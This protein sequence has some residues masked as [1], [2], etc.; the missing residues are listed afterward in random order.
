[1]LRV[2]QYVQP[3]VRNQDGWAHGSHQDAAAPERQNFCG[4]RGRFWCCEW[5]GWYCATV[6]GELAACRR[7]WRSEHPAVRRCVHPA[8]AGVDAQHDRWRSCWRHSSTN[9]LG[10]SGSFDEPGLSGCRSAVA[11]RRMFGPA[12]PLVVGRRL[13]CVAVSA[14]FVAVVLAS[15]G[16]REW[17]TCDAHCCGSFGRCCL[18]VG[19]RGR[20]RADSSAVGICRAWCCHTLAGGGDAGAEWLCDAADGCFHEGCERKE[21]PCGVPHIPVVPARV[22]GVDGGPLNTPEPRG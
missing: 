15:A 13:V 21:R 16:L 8:E 2:G 4:A 12:R 3:S 20:R 9:G 22:D 10:C 11:R 18:A 5:C 7:P 6:R 17:L 1:M 14:L 19:C